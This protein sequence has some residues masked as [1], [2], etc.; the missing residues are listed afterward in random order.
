MQRI[1]TVHLPKSIA[2]EEIRNS[3]YEKEPPTNMIA[4]PDFISLVE[5]NRLHP[6]TKDLTSPKA[7]ARALEKKEAF[8]NENI[9]LRLVPTSTTDATTWTIPRFRLTE[10][11][12][13]DAVNRGREASSPTL[14][15]S[16]LH[17]RK[18]AT[19]IRPKDVQHHCRTSPVIYDVHTTSALGITKGGV[20]SVAGD[21]YYKGDVVFVVNVPQLSKSERYAVTTDDI[22]RWLVQGAIS[23]LETMQIE[24]DK[25]ETLRQNLQRLEHDIKNVHVSPVY[26]EH[27]RAIVGSPLKDARERKFEDLQEEKNQTKRLLEK[28]KQSLEALRDKHISACSLLITNRSEKDQNRSDGK[29]V[30]SFSVKVQGKKKTF[31]TELISNKTEWNL[32]PLHA[33]GDMAAEGK[34]KQKSIIDTTTGVEHYVDLGG[35]SIEMLPDGFGVLETYSECNQFATSAN[36]ENNNARGKHSVFH[37]NFREGQYHEGILH[38]DAGVYS[39]TFL[40]NEPHRGTMKYSDSIILTGGFAQIKDDSPLGPN[41]YS[42]GL[43]H[44]SDAHIQFKNGAVYEGEMHHGSISGNG[45]FRYPRDDCVSMGKPPAKKKHGTASFNEAK[46]DFVDGVLQNNHGIEGKGASNLLRSMFGGERLWGY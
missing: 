10:S 16:H 39:G 43:P 46:G 44:G 45:S 20:L 40:S 25:I 6:S 18:S 3:L 38:T 8:L 5:T 15:V 17:D 2:P 13:Q 41:R 34:S 42:H 35:V 37:G 21:S 28:A 12:L 29:Q 32:I 19:V 23:G 30:S 24:S 22:H 33:T 31:Y 27:G 1:G 9:S 26:N 11:F 4:D 7:K 36:G 14:L